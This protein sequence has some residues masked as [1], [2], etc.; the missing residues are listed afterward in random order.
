MNL[1]YLIGDATNPVI[2]PAL[3]CHVCN[4]VNKWGA[5]FVVSL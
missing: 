4:S 5:G 3:I 1:H 2:K